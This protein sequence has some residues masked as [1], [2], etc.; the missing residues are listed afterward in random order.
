MASIREDG[1]RFAG[2]CYKGHLSD[3]GQWQ[4]F[5]RAFHGGKVKVKY[6]PNDPHRIFCLNDASGNYETLKVVNPEKIKEHARLEEILDCLKYR[7]L[8]H[9]GDTD[10][11]LLDRVA[12]NRFRDEEVK[13]AAEARAQAIAPASKVEHLSRIQDNRAFEAQVQRLLEAANRMH[14]STD[15]NLVADEDGSSEAPSDLLSKLLAETEE[16]MKND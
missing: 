9:E 16:E 3:K 8:V 5:A 13:A 12:H 14:Q 2:H 1:V 15:T 11:R 4:E 7:Q 10:I 6:N